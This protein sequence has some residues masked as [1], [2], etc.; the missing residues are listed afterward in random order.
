MGTTKYSES[1]SFEEM[2]SQNEDSVK[3]EV[4]PVET[5]ETTE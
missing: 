2:E 3:E 5:D 4:T 1:S